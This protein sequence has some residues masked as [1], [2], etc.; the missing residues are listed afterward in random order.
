MRIA[1]LTLVFFVASVVATKAQRF[2]LLPQVGFENSKTT[3]SYNDLRSVAPLGVKFTPQGS[4]RLNYAS[5]QGHGFFIG[6]AT[7]RH[8]ISYNFTDLETGM[9]DFS[10]TTGNM[11][12][13]LEGGYQ[14][15]S[16]AISLSK[17]AKSSAKK[18]SEAKKKCETTSAKSSCR[19]STSYSSR[20]G[21]KAKQTAKQPALAKNK[22]SWMRIQPSIG[23][24]FIPSVRNDV[25]AKVQNAQTTYDYAAGNWNTAIIAGTGFEFGRKNTRLFT[26]SI[27][28]YKGLGNLNTE[29]ISTQSAS[30][31]VTATLNSATSGWDVRVGIPFTLGGPRT[32][33]KAKTEKKPQLKRSCGQ[34][35]IIYRC[36]GY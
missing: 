5:K 7:S 1:A 20:C 30:K 29:T 22:G 28:Y 35:K 4:L 23:M 21:S 25:V 13:R 14:F 2:S 15:N 10:A 32:A 9:T 36:S 19:S 16:K 27:N 8:T 11:Q 24:G 31:S 3:I 34:S 6:A 26:V 12:V 18:S 33:K 17:S